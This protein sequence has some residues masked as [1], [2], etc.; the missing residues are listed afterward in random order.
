MG[1][2][3]LEDATQADRP[4]EQPAAAG[5]SGSASA[6]PR[7]EAYEGSTKETGAS[8]SPGDG[9]SNA[10][11]AEINEKRDLASGKEAPA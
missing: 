7:E 10:E 1:S 9:K 8:P 3:A 5:T 6:A 4:A 2:D 11:Q